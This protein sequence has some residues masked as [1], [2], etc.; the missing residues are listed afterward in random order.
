MVKIFY[1][2]IFCVNDNEDVD[3]KCPQTRDAL[4]VTIVKFWFITLKF[5]QGNI[6]SYTIQ[7]ITTLKKQVNANHSIIAK[8]F[9]IYI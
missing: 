8:L 6:E 3:V 9:I 2:G 7:Q 5:K 4:L 1:V